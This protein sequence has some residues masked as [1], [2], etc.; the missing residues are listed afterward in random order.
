[1]FDEFEEM[2]CN[3]HDAVRFRTAVPVEEVFVRTD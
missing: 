3:V 1:M 2:L